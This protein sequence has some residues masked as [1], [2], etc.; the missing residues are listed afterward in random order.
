MQRVAVFFDYE[1]VHRV[2]HGL[3][4]NHGTEKHTTVVDPVKLAERIVDKRKF[5]SELTQ[6]QVFRGRPVPAHQAKAASA[7]DIQAAAWAQDKR[8]VVTRRDLRYDFDQ[9]NPTSFTAREKGIDVALAIG[10]VDG[11]LRNA[12]DVAIV[13]TCD[14]DIMP[15]LELAFAKTTPSI[16][17]ACWQGRKPLWFPEGLRLNPPKR[18]PYCHFLKEQDF[19]DCRDYSAANT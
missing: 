1:N 14:T 11:A 12:F 13:F 17:I 8:V 6:I 18:F 15:A 9:N 3:Y 16:E 4:T 10:I 19:I 5:P 2:G 7:N